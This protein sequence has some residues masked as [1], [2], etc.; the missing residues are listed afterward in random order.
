MVIRSKQDSARAYLACRLWHSNSGSSTRAA[1][2]AYSVSC[3]VRVGLVCVRLCCRR[4]CAT[5]SASS[6]PGPTTLGEPHSPDAQ[7]TRR[8]PRPC[9]WPH[10]GRRGLRV[11]RRSRQPR[12]VRHARTRPPAKRMGDQHSLT[13][14][15]PASEHA[16]RPPIALPAASRTTPAPRSHPARA[17][18][19]PRSGRLR[20]RQTQGERQLSLF[21]SPFNTMLTSPDE[22]KRGQPR[23]RHG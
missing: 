2:R 17:A 6:R 9:P 23:S 13:A 3:A 20:Q 18:E 1:A 16:H 19:R 11:T 14:T 8:P 12:Q 4:T 7:Q 15:G 5:S 22:R 21:P 10:K